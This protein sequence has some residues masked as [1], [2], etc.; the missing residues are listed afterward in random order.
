MREDIELLLSHLQWS[1]INTRQGYILEG[2][3]HTNLLYG[4]AQQ[5][6]EAAEREKSMDKTEYPDEF[7]ERFD[8]G[9]APYV[10]PYP[11]DEAE[12][13]ESVLRSQEGALRSTRPNP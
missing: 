8:N 2:V 5:L 6:R 12:A 9:V 1:N 10:S 13:T 3:R 11:P 7:D 4:P